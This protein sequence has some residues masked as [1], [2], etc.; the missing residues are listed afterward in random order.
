MQRRNFSL[1]RPALSRE[2]NLVLILL[3]ILTAVILWNT[4]WWLMRIVLFVVIVYTIYQ[5]LKHYV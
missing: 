3:A 1:P 2:K 4:F 5:I